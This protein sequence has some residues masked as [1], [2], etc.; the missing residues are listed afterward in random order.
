MGTKLSAVNHELEVINPDLCSCAQR[1]AEDV[2]LGFSGDKE[3]EVV[4][5][6]RLFKFLHSNSLNFLNT[7]KLCQDDIGQCNATVNHA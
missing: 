3:T 2:L 1:G 4:I 5:N 6:F 7:V